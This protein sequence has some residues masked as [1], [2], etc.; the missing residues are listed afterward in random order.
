MKKR[1]ILYLIFI[2][3]VFLCASADDGYE[4]E[5]EGEPEEPEPSVIR[6]GERNSNMNEKSIQL[7]KEENQ[8]RKK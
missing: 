3:G 5:P 4:D 6:I 1:V 8:S 2:C 7:M